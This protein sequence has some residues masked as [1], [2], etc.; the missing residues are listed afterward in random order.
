MRKIKKRRIMAALLAAILA[1]A[2]IPVGMGTLAAENDPADPPLGEVLPEEELPTLGES[3]GWPDSINH[4]ISGA[5]V[6]YPDGTFM[7]MNE[8]EAQVVARDVQRYMRVSLSDLL[9]GGIY[10]Y[11]SALVFPTNH[12]FLT[13]DTKNTLWICESGVPEGEQTK[14]A[15]NVVDFVDSVALMENGNVIRTYEP[16]QVMLSNVRQIDH[17]Y[18]Y[19]YAVQ[20]DG[21]LWQYDDGGHFPIWSDWVDHFVKI[22]ENITDYLGYGCYIK[23]GTTYRNRHPIVETVADSAYHGGREDG[24]VFVTVGN[25][26]ISQQAGNGS[27]TVLTEDLY[28]PILRDAGDL[29]GYVTGEGTAYDWAGRELE[30]PFPYSEIQKMIEFRDV[31]LILKKDGT[32]W[33][34]ETNSE[35]PELMMTQVLD[36][37]SDDIDYHPLYAI[38][39]DGTVWSY[40]PDRKTFLQ[41]ADAPEHSDVPSTDSPA[42][43]ESVVTPPAA[44]IP[45]NVAELLLDDSVLDVTVT[46][47]K[48]DVV[49][50]AIFAAAQQAGKP[51]AFDIRSQDGRTNYRWTFQN[52]TDASMDLNLAIAFESENAAAIQQI[53]GQQELFFLSFAHHGALPG[54][55][56]VEVYVGDRYADGDSLLL[57]YYN[58]KTNDVELVDSGVQ[59][60]SSYASFTI[61]HCSD[62]FLTDTAVEKT[63]DNNVTTES[64]GITATEDAVNPS[65]GDMG[66]V[67]LAAGTA[68][69][70]AAGTLLLLRRKRNA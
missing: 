40:H 64:S 27:V 17:A 10:N 70:A 19:V 52:I 48:P 59:V 67:F 66:A 61:D 8:T 14:I 35:E 58:E 18:G 33:N 69:A 11:T 6:L 4:W 56:T 38:R 57:Y 20:E 53:A 32:L 9:P 25:T 28:K 65:T 68:T 36:F 24:Y 55:A 16:H 44:Q 37:V 43:A 34:T 3:Y 7:L 39:A 60:S 45:G 22:D 42:D 29:F 1:A 46:L 47:T 13:L 23:N 63:A 15:D 50:R 21:T 51:I 54:A 5:E 30:L 49:D 12:Y 31:S 26:L 2:A 41:I 62:Y